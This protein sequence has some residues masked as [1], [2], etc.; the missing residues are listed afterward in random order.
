MLRTV[1]K[2]LGL[3]LLVPVVIVGGILAYDYS[4]PG[5]R[6]RV[7]PER[8]IELVKQRVAE[9]YAREE[10]PFRDL[11]LF[12]I[13]RAVSFDVVVDY[14]GSARMRRYE[15]TVTSY[16][17]LS[18]TDSTLS[19]SSDYVSHSLKGFGPS[20]SALKGAPKDRVSME[21]VRGSIFKSLQRIMSSISYGDL[22]STIPAVYLNRVY[23]R[24]HE[25]IFEYKHPLVRSVRA[26]ADCFIAI[27]RA[28]FE[29][30]LWNFHEDCF[31]FRVGR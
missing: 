14:P 29:T 28:G 26:G 20:G 4:F 17:M 15:G 25:I 22:D 27:A 7:Q 16:L 31:N 2:Y 24:D 12:S 23:M 5:P 6:H 18:A 3:S 11:R 1:L 21:D 13:G 9:G 8:L 19:L 10:Y 30:E